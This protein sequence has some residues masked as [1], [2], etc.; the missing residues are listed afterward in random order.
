MMYI[1]QIKTLMFIEKNPYQLLVDQCFQFERL[2][3]KETFA[4]SPSEYVN[5]QYFRFG[6]EFQ[7]SV[8]PSGRDF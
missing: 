4:I 1:Y 7:L 5:T 8:R 6:R 2:N 3:I